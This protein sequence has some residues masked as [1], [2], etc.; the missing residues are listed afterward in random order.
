MKQFRK[1][2]SFDLSEMT[3]GIAEARKYIAEQSAAGN[4]EAAKALNNSR[5]VFKLGYAT[6]WTGKRELCFQIKP[7]PMIDLLNVGEPI[8]VSNINYTPELSELLSPERLSTATLTVSGKITGEMLEKI[9]RFRSID[10][11]F[12]KDADFSALRSADL[13]KIRMS[14]SN[15]PAKDL[16]YMEE[17]CMVTENAGYIMTITK[18]AQ[19]RIIRFYNCKKIPHLTDVHFPANVRH[20]VI[21]AE[22]RLT[23]KVSEIDF[24]Q[25]QSL[26]TLQ[27]NNFNF[28]DCGQISLPKN[29]TYL[30]FGNCTLKPCKTFDLDV[31]PSLQQV[32]LVASDLSGIK[33]IVFP[34]AM[35]ECSINGCNFKTGSVLDYSHCSKP[36]N[37]EF[38]GLGSDQIFCKEIL[39]PVSLKQLHID[40]AVFQ[41]LETLDLGECRQLEKVYFN[42]VNFPQ[43]KKLIVPECEF[44][45]NK[46]TAA[47]Y[48]ETITVAPQQAVPPPAGYPRTA[49]AER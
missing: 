48:T 6:R 35:E 18:F 19:G 29:L 37:L 10:N 7:E 40:H 22:N 15:V 24:A 30:G 14:E 45:Q 32:R 4:Q 23:D 8:K 16:A 13:S 17:A 41:Q 43:L 25:Y 12:F 1:I 9:A 26:E 2:D 33:R 38:S 5:Y 31:C 49:G 21:D 11:L 27:F 44:K 47:P 42:H 3:E 36:T 46:F 34:S 20:L 28:E 39:M